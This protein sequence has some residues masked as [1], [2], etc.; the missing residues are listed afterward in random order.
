MKL[1]SHGFQFGQFLTIPINARGKNNH[2]N[3]VTQQKPAKQ[4]QMCPDAPQSENRSTDDHPP[5]R[6]W[7]GGG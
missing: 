3:P 2:F 7:A 4:R 6:L 5:F 1:D